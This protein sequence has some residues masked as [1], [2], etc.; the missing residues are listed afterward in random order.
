MLI[1]CFN[2]PIREGHMN[3][4]TVL[5]DALKISFSGRIN[6]TVFWVGQLFWTAAFAGL[7][8]AVSR[9]IREGDQIQTGITGTVMIAF[10]ALYEIV[11]LSLYV[12]RW[13]DR[14]KSGWWHL[15]GLIPFIGPA[16]IL[17]ECGLQAGTRGE[18]NFGMPY[19]VPV[20][21]SSKSGAVEREQDA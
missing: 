16:W 13:H 17:G 1:I 19:G 2:E 8:F 21:L 20:E 3:L 7:L 15:V 12:R 4:R 10:F 5:M 18:N 11:G 9:T 6:R 14:N